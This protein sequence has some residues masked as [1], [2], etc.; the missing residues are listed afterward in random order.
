MPPNRSM[1]GKKAMGLA[2]VA[3]AMAALGH[4]PFGLWPVSLLGFCAL[5]CL[6]AT[7]NTTRQATLIGWAGGVGYFAITLHWIVEPFLV[8]A[9]RQG[10]MA[11]FALILITSG[12]ALFWGLA[13][14]VA[15]RIGSNRAI[16][17]AVA[18]SAAEMLRAYVFTGFPWAL[19]GYIWTDTA[20]RETAALWGPFA[21]TLITLL[22]TALLADAVLSKPLKRWVNVAMALVGFLALF[23]YAPLRD[24]ELVTNENVVRLVQPNAPQDEKWDPDKALIF[25]DRQIEF[26]AAPDTLDLSPDLII[27]P[28]TAIP[29]RLDRAGPL[30]SQIAAA[31]K[32]VPVITG[33]N[34]R[35]A[36]RNFNSLISIG[37]TGQPSDVYDKVHLVPFGEYIPF[38]QMARAIGMGSL[39]ARDGFGFSPGES[40]RLID[41]P[42]GR[43][44][45][46]ICYE[47]IFPQHGGA[48]KDRP[49]YLLQITNDAW[50]GTFSGPYQHLDQARFRAAEQGLPLIRVANT[51]VSAI[52]D[53]RGYVQE[54]LPL[55]VA[56]YLDAAMPGRLA[57][58]TLY[59]KTGDWP[60]VLFLIAAL[61]ALFVRGR[62]N[63]I[64]KALGTEYRVLT[65]TT[66]SWRG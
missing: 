20:V 30:L 36:G 59:A 65:A 32:G 13:G 48:L 54:T 6:V 14:F 33:I 23:A 63:S 2:A 17:W 27:W 25:V 42:L 52:I 37:S 19:P 18:L 8:D 44:L 40:V 34:R 9:A 41:T 56:G 62:G 51:G 24:P 57:E 58:P 66:A 7:A 16:G 46:L 29:Y 64:A 3:G 61:A 49:G 45:P 53:P 15:R 21:L 38:G 12:L 47:V 10:W 1:N 5:S 55:G 31:A 11:P 50:F 4:A 39:A 43:A 26:T 35:E 60:T 22:L 28:E